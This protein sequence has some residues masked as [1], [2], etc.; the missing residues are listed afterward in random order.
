M[1]G[2][3]VT[4]S[5][6]IVSID[7]YPLPAQLLG[8]QIDADRDINCLKRRSEIA[9]SMFWLRKGSNIKK[10]LR[11]RVIIPERVYIIVI[12]SSICLQEKLN[13]SVGL[14]KEQNIMT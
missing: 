5:V 2:I 4:F 8:L 3:E 9:G 13:C 14:Q 12:I 11:K 10:W 6:L 1:T 7:Q